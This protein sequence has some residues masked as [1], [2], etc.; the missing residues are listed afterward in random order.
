MLKTLKK[1]TKEEQITAEVERISALFESADA[2]KKALVTPLIKNAAFMSVT[3]DEMQAIINRDGVIDHYTN[4]KNQGGAKASAAVQGYNS[5][6]KNYAAVVKTLLGLVPLEVFERKLTK[7]Q[8]QAKPEEPAETE[9]ERR[10]RI[11]AEIERAA[12][13]QREQRAKERAEKN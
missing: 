4:G 3:L 6:V 10:A 7:I 13:W 1:L 12:A 5:L 2:N 8:E 11:N 9:K